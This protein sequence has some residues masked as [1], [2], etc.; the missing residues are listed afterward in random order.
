MRKGWRKLLTGL[1]FGLS[2]FLSGATA[3]CPAAWDG[4]RPVKLTIEV[5]WTAPTPADSSSGKD[6][7]EVDFEV[8]EGRIIEVVATSRGLPGSRGRGPE[9]KSATLWRLGSERGGRVRARIETSPGANL[10]FTAG[11]QPMSFPL[12][13]VLEGP[14]HT[15][16]QSPVEITV[17]RVAWDVI[18]V[19]L[20]PPSKTFSDKNPQAVATPIEGVVAPGAKVAVSVAFNVL[21]PEPTEVAMRCTAELKPI[22]GGDAVWRG[23]LGD[24]VVP[25]NA[26]SPPSFL[27]SVDVPKIEGTYVLEIYASW[28]PALAHDGGKL[29]GRLIRRGRRGMIGSSTASR[30]IT[31][32][33]LGSEEKNEPEHAK[34]GLEQEVDAI[35]L[36]RPRV[37]RPTASGRS[38]PPSPGRSAWPVPAE[39][40]TEATRRDLLR[41]WIARVGP[42]VAQLAPA[43]SSG[44]A[45]SAL[46]LKVARPGRPHRLTV[47]V[48]GGH[49]SA[50]GVALVGIGASAKVGSRPR[51]LLDACASG[52]PIVAN[53]PPATFSWPVWPDVSDPV[54]V[55]VNRAAGT[56]VQLGTITLTELAE[57][58]EAPTIE[59]PGDAPSRGLGLYLTGTDLL[60]RFGAAV[61]P[62]FSDTLN[63]TKMLAR[64]ARSCG[65]SAVVLPEALADRAVRRALDGQAA[66]DATGPDHLA[67][68]LNSLAKRGVSSWVEL[69]INGGTALPGLPAPGDPEAMTRGLVRCDRNGL[70]DGPSSTYHPIAPEVG[71]AL[72]RRVSQAVNAYK[73]NGSLAGIL[74][75]LGTGPTLLGPADTGF[76]DATFSRFIR[77]AFDFETAKSLPGLNAEDPER[78][79]ARS[80][81]LAGSGR[82]PWLI[83]RSKQVAALYA[84][85]ADAVKEAK[86]TARLAVSTPG[87]GDGPAGSEARRADLAGLAPSL[88]WR[89]VGLDLET[90]ATGES[91]PIVFRGANLGADG[92]AHDLATSPELD[93]KV[94]ARP[95]RG[96]LIDVEE[97]PETGRPG[98]SLSAPVIDAGPNGD[99]PL[100]HALASLDARWV[101]L[102]GSA[103]VGNEERCRRFVRVFCAL[104]ATPPAERQPLP[105]GVSVRAYPSGG[106]TYLALANDTPYPIRLDTVLNG[107][108]SASVYDLGRDRVLRPTSDA[109]GRHLVLDLLPFG[110]AAV[111]IGA[112]EVKL[113]SVTPYPSENVLSG[114]NA[115]YEALSARLSKLSRGGDKDVSKEKDLPRTGPANLGFEP[116]EPQPTPLPPMPVPSETASKAT[117]NALETSGQ[118]PRG[119]QVVGGMGSGVVIDLK[120]PHTGQGSL[121]LDAHDPAASVVS[122]DFVPVVQ[123]VMLVRA[124]LRSDRADAKVRVWI[125]GE[126]N[127]HKYRRVSEL[128]VQTSWSERAVRASDVPIGGLDS[129]RLRFELLGA[130]SLWIDDLS[131]TGEVLS[132]PERRNTR[133]ALLAAIQAYR[134]KRFADFAR[135]SGSHWARQ[136]S[137]PAA[138]G[139]GP[140]PSP[141]RVASDRG[142]LLR[143]GEASELPRNRRLR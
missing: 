52:A 84:N 98:L 125:E 136:S 94:A 33:V 16:P 18:S 101:W 47:T 41:G 9:R 26:A 90:W 46:G 53:G 80:R 44:F 115:Q 42:E 19:D 72:K 112:P 114:M 60:D 122:D 1:G 81:F 29:I 35:D 58:A 74:I 11:G 38:A 124:W 70:P 30:R 103:V 8:S 133:N 27:L 40:L 137:A 135:L 39:A 56:G 96:V 50:L 73:T 31:L 108:V 28:E 77:E 3:P 142:G 139:S 110:I 130:G 20:S 14:Q 129:A 67:L 86:P 21:S 76:D 121:R 117:E 15:P 78:F 107:P 99:E 87:P 62:G 127:G 64:Y 32:A 10:R 92:L 95:D 113:S 63:A 120:Q 93:A 140:D 105:F 138:V 24:V 12:P 23:G 2:W 123:N 13:V 131:V 5:A 65:A 66:E 4:S 51:R 54:L 102:A 25:T 68:A 100:G 91:T 71:D 118:A 134:E 49:P 85:L 89:A 6:G 116:D 36:S 82:M 79:A 132:E 7:P 109:S 97:S 111:R 104:P 141:D 57:V 119:W 128:S 61:E 17:E 106:Q 22:R 69:D 37:H 43:D 83:W 59:P 34:V 75:R 88:A 126:S 143:S 48:T 55:L 45:W